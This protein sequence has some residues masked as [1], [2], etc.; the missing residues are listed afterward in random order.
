MGNWP[1]CA[2]PVKSHIAVLKGEGNSSLEFVTIVYQFRYNI[3][4]TKYNLDVTKYQTGTQE[5]LPSS[6]VALAF[7]EV[8]FSHRASTSSLSPERVRL[9]VTRVSAREPKVHVSQQGTGHVSQLGDGR[10]MYV[11]K[12]WKVH[13]SQQGEGRYMHLDKRI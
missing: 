4:I 11:S 9:E 6:A 2:L 10:Y 1:D 5:R 8:A 13:V 3:Q 12:G 7:L